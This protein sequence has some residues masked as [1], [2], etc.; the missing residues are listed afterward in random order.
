MEESSNL[1]WEEE[2]HQQNDNSHDNCG[3]SC[4]KVKIPAPAKVG[5]QSDN[6]SFIVGKRED[7]GRIVYND[8]GIWEAGKHHD[9]SHHQHEPGSSW[10]HK[11]EQQHCEEV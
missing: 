2:V 1:P 9:E 10:N 5:S 4:E 7:Q 8:D 11:Y 3:D 6:M